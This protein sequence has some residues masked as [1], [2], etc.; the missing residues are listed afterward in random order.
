MLQGFWGLPYLGM[1]INQVMDL[2]WD[3][4]PT[5]LKE[6]KRRKKEELSK[7]KQEEAHPEACW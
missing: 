3:L 5:P 1:T 7:Q 2:A 6:Y 4:D